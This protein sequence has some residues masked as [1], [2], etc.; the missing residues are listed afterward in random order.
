MPT[1]SVARRRANAVRQPGELGATDKPQDEQQHDRPD[2]GH[3]EA[4]DAPLEIGPAS[5]E[6]SK[7]ETAQEGADDADDD[8]FQ[9]ALLAI[10]PRDHAGHPAGKRA[11]DDPGDDAETAFHQGLP[12][13]EESVR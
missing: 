11:K 9:P 4:A 5:G 1:L 8:V 3:D 13:G 2:D 7:K 6:E 10:R 12:S